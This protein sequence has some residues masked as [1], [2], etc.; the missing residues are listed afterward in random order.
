ML[1]IFFFCHLFGILI[2]FSNVVKG[3]ELICGTFEAVDGEKDP[4]CLLQTF[5]IIKALVQ[6][7]PD[8]SGPLANYCAD[9]FE[10][11]G[12]YFPIHFTHVSSFTSPASY[13]VFLLIFSLN[14]FLPLL[15][16]SLPSHYSKMNVGSSVKYCTVVS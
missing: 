14:F 6:L 9:L 2:S 7:F 8:P 11:L 15:L 4:Q 12:C 5:L 1:N 10:I 3:E 16:R 13:S